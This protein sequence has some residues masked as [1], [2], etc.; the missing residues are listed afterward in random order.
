MWPQ[1]KDCYQLAARRELTH[2]QKRSGCD[3]YEMI[4]KDNILSGD[5]SNFSAPATGI[6]CHA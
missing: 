6:P 2:E 5:L 4:D 3:Q 1:G